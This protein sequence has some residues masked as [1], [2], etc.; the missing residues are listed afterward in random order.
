MQLSFLD[1]AARWLADIRVED[2]EEL[3]EGKIG[4]LV[5]WMCSDISNLWLRYHGSCETVCPR[6]AFELLIAMSVGENE[7]V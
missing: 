4:R 3:R 6:K 7:E 5:F 1:G 2:F